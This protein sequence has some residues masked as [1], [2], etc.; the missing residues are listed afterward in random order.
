MAFVRGRTIFEERFVETAVQFTAPSLTAGS[1]SGRLDWAD[2]A[3]TV[4]VATAETAVDPGR[5]GV[6]SAVPAGRTSFGHRPAT[7]SMSKGHTI[8]SEEQG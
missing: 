2:S 6:W 8:T 4:G 7:T 3:S 5:P 1:I